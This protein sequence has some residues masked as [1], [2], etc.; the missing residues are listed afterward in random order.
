VKIERGE[1]TK[2][3]VLREQL[4]AYLE[5]YRKTNLNL[6]RF[7]EIIQTHIGPG[8]NEPVNL[9]TGAPSENIAL[10]PR[11]NKPMISSQT[12]NGSHVISCT[13]FPEC[14]TS[15]FLPR[16]SKFV[17]KGSQCPNCHGYFICSYHFPL[18]SVP[19]SMTGDFEGCLK[20]SLG[21]YYKFNFALFIDN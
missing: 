11:C 9:P 18:G 10:C 13:G 16:G 4:E 15:G 6:S 3:V 19:A 7:Y 5:A 14:K 21:E 20:C 8:S 2:E 1:K 12:K 17:S